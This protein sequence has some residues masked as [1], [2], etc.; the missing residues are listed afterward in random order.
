MSQELNK[1][2]NSSLYDSQT[3][4]SKL[5]GLSQLASVIPAVGP[6]ISALGSVVLGERQNRNLAKAF[7]KI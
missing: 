7:Q 4:D 1:I 5:A 2:Q 6:I 3:A